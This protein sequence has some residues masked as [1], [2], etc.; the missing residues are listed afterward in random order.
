MFN[1]AWFAEQIKQGIRAPEFPSGL[2]WLNTGGRELHFNKELKG[3]I[4]I[5][6]FWTYCCINCMHVLPDLAF[7]EEKYAGKP[8]VILG[9]HSAKFNNE[10]ETINIRQAI[11]RYTI[12]HPVVVDE[13][14]KI[15]DS[16]GV[17]SWPTLVAV[18]PDG[19]ILGGFS[20]EG[21]RA[22]LDGLISGALTYYGKRNSLARDGLTLPLELVK[23]P[24]SELL[25]PGK[26]LID[27]AAEA[28]FYCGFQPQ[29]CCG[30][31]S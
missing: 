2:Q 3:R 7:L 30:H 21:H 4:V 8:V 22:E 14:L 11:L 6:D 16:F 1:D 12:R 31:Q 27:P 13:N 5:I 29:S 26:V 24:P 23:E 19:L 17:N 25:Y 20:G 10:Q 18:G 9:C 28:A 15:W